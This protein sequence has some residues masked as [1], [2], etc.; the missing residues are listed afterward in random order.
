MISARDASASEKLHCLL[1]RIEW[2]KIVAVSDGLSSDSN[3]RLQLGFILYL[4][5][6]E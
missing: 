5:K 6:V 2:R 1:F 4:F 3:V